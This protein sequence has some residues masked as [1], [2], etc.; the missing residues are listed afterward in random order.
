MLVAFSFSSAM[1]TSILLCSSSMEVDSVSYSA[2]VQTRQPG[3][4]KVLIGWRFLITH[5]SFLR[6]LAAHVSQA[7]HLGLELLRFSGYLLDFVCHLLALLVDLVALPGE[8][9]RLK[10]IFAW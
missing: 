1:C 6:L 5:L 2:C 7:L 9:F 8:H 3:T 10:I 4:V